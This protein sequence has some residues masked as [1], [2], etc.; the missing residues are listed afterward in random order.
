MIC[1]SIAQQSRRLTPVDMLK[2]GPQ[3]DLLEVRLDRFEKAA[4]VAEVL[5]HK[6]RPV[7]MACR[8]GEDGGDWLGHEQERLALL[9]Q[10]VVGKADYVE[11]ELDVADQVRPFRR[12]L[13]V[14]KAPAAVIDAEH[15][16]AVR[17]VVDEVKPSARAAGGPISSPTRGG[18][19]RA[20]TCSPGRRCATWRTSWGPG[21]SAST[22]YARRI[23]GRRSTWTRG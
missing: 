11:V 8:R 9:R 7:I 21:A 20:T 14:V 19:G 4:N 6:P 16:S 1:V 22:P 13:E 3:C 5:A 17:G 2:A 15:Q 23:T 12:V 18:S 10:C